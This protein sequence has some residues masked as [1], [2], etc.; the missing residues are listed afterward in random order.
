VP[1]F[2]YEPG[3]AVELVTDVQQITS[4]P[5]PHLADL[6]LDGDRDIVR[7]DQNQLTV[8]DNTAP[9]LSDLPRPELQSIS[10][11]TTVTAVFQFPD[12]EPFPFTDAEFVMWVSPPDGLSITP[13]GTRVRAPIVGTDVTFNVPITSGTRFFAIC[14]GLTVVGGVTTSAGPAYLGWS[15]YIGDKELGGLPP[16]PYV[17]PPPPNNPPTV[18][19]GG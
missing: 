7:F 15:F 13:Q 2:R 12:M 3:Y 9:G 14:R 10:G 19:G 16:Q 11:S 5:S 6:D 18:P 1:T 8:I 4:F 17:P